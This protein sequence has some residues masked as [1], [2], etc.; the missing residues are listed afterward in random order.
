M[1]KE[2]RNRNDVI[3]IDD[4]D[5]TPL[6]ERAAECRKRAKEALFESGKALTEIEKE[7]HRIAAEGWL[8]LA[9]KIDLILG[10]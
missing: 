5:D 7:T 2:Q 10:A 4:I 8:L 6:S 9:V 3:L 1:G